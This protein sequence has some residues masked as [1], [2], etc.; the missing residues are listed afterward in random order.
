MTQKIE[1]GVIPSP[2][3][4]PPSP[5]PP[6]SRHNHTPLPNSTTTCNHTSPPPPPS[7]PPPSTR[8]PSPPAPPLH[9]SLAINSHPS[10]HE[11]LPSNSIKLG[12][13]YQNDNHALLPTS[14]VDHVT[15]HAGHMILR[16]SRDPHSGDSSSLG[17]TLYVPVESSQLIRPKLKV[18]SNGE[19]GAPSSHSHGHNFTGLGPI[20]RELVLKVSPACAPSPRNLRYRPYPADKT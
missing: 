17:Q 11:T 15:S 20:S 14:C 6:S 4:S 1:S 2:A 3:H 8:S 19:C 16:S 5:P 18:T 13:N 10:E 12:K 7:P 9:N